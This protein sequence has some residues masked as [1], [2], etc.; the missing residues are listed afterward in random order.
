LGGRSSS[1]G[2]GAFE[3][4][5]WALGRPSSTSK[6]PSTGSSWNSPSWTVE[7]G[8]KSRGSN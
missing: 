5:V 8:R 3:T 4:S 7:F 2:W 1:I 6:A